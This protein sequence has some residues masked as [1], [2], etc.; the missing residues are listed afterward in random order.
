MYRIESFI[1]SGSLG[2]IRWEKVGILLVSHG[3][4]FF[5]SELSILMWFDVYMGLTSICIYVT[6]DWPWEDERW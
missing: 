1:V 3:K 6:Y 5:F 2:I 4:G